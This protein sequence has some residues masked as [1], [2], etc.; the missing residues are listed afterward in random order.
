MILLKDIIDDHN[1]LLREISEPVSLPLS[2]EDHQLLM[3]MYEY[4]QNSQDEEKS[5]ALDL[6]PGVGLAAI[7]IGVKKRMC[8][9]LIYDYNEDGE[10][11]DAIAYALVN[12][13]IV[14]HSERIAYLK[15]GEGCLSVNKDHKGYV[16]RYAKV[17]IKAYDALTQKDVTI[18]ARGYEAIVYQHELDHFDGHLFYDHI[19]SQNPYKPIENALEIE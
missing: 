15:D 17:T 10:I 19:N 6:R 3:D 16:P 13:R 1:P 2:K 8:A 14:S 5:E 9:I 4:L 18:V 12:P 7:H 11:I